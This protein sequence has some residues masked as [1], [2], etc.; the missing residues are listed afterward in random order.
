MPRY[1]GLDLHK[2]YVHG[3]EFRPELPSGQQERH[4]R[5]P[6][7]PSA[8]AEFVAQLDPDTWVA[9]EVTGNAF[10]IY[11]LLSPHAGKVLPANPVEL[12]R[13][14]SGRHTDRVD[15]ARLAKMAALGTVPVVW[16]PPQPMRQ[17]RRLLACRERV[18]KYRRALLN[19]V[20]AVCR[21]HGL[22]VPQ[23][24]SLVRWLETVDLSELPAGEQAIVW[25]TLQAAQVLEAQVEALTAEVARHVAAIPEVQRLLSITGVGIL[26]A[27]T[28]WAKIGDPR[29]FRGPKQVARY[30]GLDPSV[31][32]SGERDRRGRITLHGD[33]LL[34]R[35]LIEAAWSVSRHETGALGEFY[36]RK[37]RQL[38]AKQAI[39]AL[40]RKLLIVAWRILLTGEPYRAQKLPPYSTSKP[41]CDDGRA[42]RRIGRPS[43]K[44]SLRPPAP[45]LQRHRPDAASSDRYG[46]GLHSPPH[47]LRGLDFQH[48]WVIFQP[49][50]M[51]Q[52]STGLDSIP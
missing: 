9:F 33:R 13:L 3:C 46:Q 52:N 28:V 35:M 14:G 21:R 34:R 29:R 44:T 45:K 38:G 24:V 20:R 4:F 36:R 12:K 47:A 26:T 10:E 19:Q 37:V 41:G 27:A 51:G 48:K 18:D 43:G 30:A 11:D 17:V 49:P 42:E 2:A 6:N 31:E 15:A 8:W 7:T 32:Q 39:V 25:A 40:A 16:V 50:K 1:V 5:F 22:Q 23:R